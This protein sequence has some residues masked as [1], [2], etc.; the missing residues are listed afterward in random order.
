MDARLRISGMTAE[1]RRSKKSV[2]KWSKSHRSMSFPHPES[3]RESGILL[4]EA[5]KDSGQAGMTQKS[6]VG[7]LYEEKLTVLWD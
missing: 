2:Y 7:R 3:V 4:R 5:Q 6:T 1:E